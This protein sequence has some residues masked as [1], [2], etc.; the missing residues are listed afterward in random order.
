MRTNINIHTKRNEE[1]NFI[2]LSFF[3]NTILLF[4]GKTHGELTHK[5]GKINIF[6]GENKN[7]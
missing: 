5:S 6:A 4:I 3:T 7:Q 1:I 2:K